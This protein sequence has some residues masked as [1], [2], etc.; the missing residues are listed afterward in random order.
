MNVLS[1][2]TNELIC[3]C[4][5]VCV[6]MYMNA[7]TPVYMQS[8][9]NGAR[10]PVLNSSPNSFDAKSLTESATRLEASKTQKS[11][12]LHTSP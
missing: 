8:P 4:V 3:V 12:F 6:Y 1:F 11:S 7:Q 2:R 9:E 10:G 5:C